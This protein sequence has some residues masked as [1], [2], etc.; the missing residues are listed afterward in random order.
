M[1][2]EEI[3]QKKLE[4]LEEPEK[5]GEM[6]KDEEDSDIMSLYIPKPPRAELESAMARLRKLFYPF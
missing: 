1:D 5:I 4:T 2:R 6:E 3:L